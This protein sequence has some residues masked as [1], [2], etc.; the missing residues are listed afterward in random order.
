[1]DVASG[2]AKRK[3]NLGDTLLEGVATVMDFL[4]DVAQQIVLLAHKIIVAAHDHYHQTKQA[5]LSDSASVLDF[6]G[7]SFFV[8]DVAREIA[9][10]HAVFIEHRLSDDVQE[11][12]IPFARVGASR[13]IYFLLSHKEEA[14]TRQNLLRGVIEG[15]SGK[16]IEGFHNNRLKGKGNDANTILTAEGA[17]CRFGLQT[18]DGRLFH[19]EG[20]DPTL[21]KAQ[22]KTKITKQGL[23][24][25]GYARL[26]TGFGQVN[27]TSLSPINS[28]Q[29][30]E[31]STAYSLAEQLVTHEDITAYLQ[32]V[33]SA[34]SSSDSKTT[35]LIISFHDFLRRY[36]PQRFAGI[37]RAVF[38]GD[39]K[40]ICL[41]GGNF[42][43]VDFS[44]AT[45]YGDISQT[46][47]VD[48]RLHGTKFV[49]ITATRSANFTRANLTYAS[50]QAVHF[51]QVTF[52]QTQWCYANLQ[53]SRFSS[54]EC[55][56]T[57]WAY[58]YYLETVRCESESV[59]LIDIQQSQEK[60][61]FELLKRLDELDKEMLG[62]YEK[63]DLINEQLANLKLEVDSLKAFSES[64]ATSEKLDRLRRE[65]KTQREKLLAL[66]AKQDE[67]DH[68]IKN[69]N[70]EMQAQLI[71]LK[72]S[73]LIHL[74]GIQKIS[75]EQQ[76][77]I[78]QQ[79][80]C[81]FQLRDQL[82]ALS[83]RV[84]R[85]E[86]KQ[87]AQE[88]LLDDHETRL[89]D[90]ERQVSKD[91]FTG[92]LRQII[93][94]LAQVKNKVE[95]EKVFDKLKQLLSG[96]ATKTVDNFLKPEECPWS[97]LSDINQYHRVAHANDSVN[98]ELLTVQK[99]YKKLVNIE[100]NRLLLRFNPNESHIQAEVLDELYELGFSGFLKLDQRKRVIKAL[101][102]QL[103]TPD[104]SS[105][106]IGGEEYPFALQHARVLRLYIDILVQQ[107]LAAKAKGVETEVAGTK[108]KR[109][110]LTSL[111][112]TLYLKTG[113]RSLKERFKA[114]ED[115]VFEQ[116]KVETA[117]KNLTTLSR[118]FYPNRR[119]R[120][121]FYKD[122]SDAIEHELI[123]A[124][125]GL[126]CLA[127][128]F[129][130]LPSTVRSAELEANSIK[131][132]P[133]VL[134]SGFKAFQQLSD[135]NYL[136]LLCWRSIGSTLIQTIDENQ[137]KARLLELQKTLAEAIKT[138]NQTLSYGLL[139]VLRCIT[140]YAR[141]I[142]LRSLAFLGSSESPLGIVHFIEA[143][144]KEGEMASLHYLGLH[145]CK[146]LM[147]NPSHPAFL[148]LV[149]RLFFF[150]QPSV[151]KIEVDKIVELFKGLLGAY[152]AYTHNPNYHKE[153]RTLLSL[154]LTKRLNKLALISY[155]GVTLPELEK[156]ILDLAQQALQIN[157]PDLWSRWAEEHTQE[158]AQLHRVIHQF[159]YVGSQQATTPL[160][161]ARYY[162]SY[163]TLSLLTDQEARFAV[164]CCE[165]NLSL[166]TA[167]NRLLDA[168]FVHRD[169]LTQRN[170]EEVLLFETHLKPFCEA[171]LAVKQDYPKEGV[172]DYL[173]RYLLRAFFP[174]E[175]LHNSLESLLRSEQFLLHIPTEIKNWLIQQNS[176]W[177][178]EG[179]EIPQLNHSFHVEVVSH[180]AQG[181][182]SLGCLNAQALALLDEQGQLKRH[183]KYAASKTPVNCL[184]G[185]SSLPGL[186]LKA[187]PGLPAYE[188]A[189]KSL[190]WH[191]TG[192]WHASRLLW[193]RM[194]RG[195]SEVRFYPVLV[196]ATLPGSTLNSFSQSNELVTQQKKQDAQFDPKI[197]Q[198]TFSWQVIFALVS[199]LGDAKS[200]NYILSPEGSVQSIDQEEILGRAFFPPQ[201]LPSEQGRKI[202]HRIG[203]KNILFCMPEMDE[204]VEND[205][206][207]QFLALPAETLFRVFLADMA[208]YNRQLQGLENLEERY[209][210]RMGAG[211]K[212]EA[213]MLKMRMRPEALQQSYYALIELQKF[214]R[215]E[216]QG[217]RRVSHRDLL[218]YLE[219]AL[220]A[221][222]QRAFD[223]YATPA[224]RFKVITTGLY[225]IVETETIEETPVATSEK[226]SA[227]PRVV[228]T[229]HHKSLSTVLLL[230]H[231][232]GDCRKKEDFEQ[233]Q[234][235]YGVASESPI[236][237]D[238]CTE[239][240]TTWA[241]H[242]AVRQAL[243]AMRR[244]DFSYLQT[245]LQEDTQARPSDADLPLRLKWQ[246]RQRSLFNF[247]FQRLDFSQINIDEKLF[248]EGLINLLGKSFF[249]IKKLHIIGAKTLSDEQFEKIIS[250][251][252]D[253]GVIKLENCALLGQD[254]FIM[255]GKNCPRLAVIIIDNLPNLE[256]ITAWGYE[257]R[258]TYPSLTQLTVAHCPQLKLINI[259]A[260]NLRHLCLES[261]KNLNELRT[262]SKN[263]HSL[264]LIR[265]EKITDSEFGEIAAD[266]T[267]LQK[268][269][270]TGCTQLQDI[271][272]VMPKLAVLKA[273]GCDA[274]RVFAARSDVLTH[275]D[276]SHNPLLT[277]EGLTD[278]MT[279]LSWLRSPS[280]DCNGSGQLQGMT[281]VK[282]GEACLIQ[283]GM[284]ANEAPLLF[285]NLQDLVNRKLVKMDLRRHQIGDAG[286]RALAEVLKEDRTLIRMD[287][288]GNKI[289]NAG[290]GALAEVL[291][292]NSTLTQIDLG[293]NQ[294]SDAGAGAL[295]EALKEN[296]TLTQMDL[297][298]NKI[299]DAGARAL[300]DA[301]KGDNTMEDVMTLNIT[302]HMGLR[303]LA[304]NPT[305]NGTL[306]QMDL[307]GNIIDSDVLDDIKFLLE[308]NHALVRYTHSS[309][310]AATSG[311]FFQPSLPS[312]SGKEIALLRKAP[313]EPKLAA[314]N[315]P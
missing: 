80:F 47:F 149:E 15:R 18:V 16:G 279:V 61:L 65:M 277:E 79:Q 17:Y 19:G 4:P 134:K 201:T 315:H 181:F 301:L 143:H 245:L 166:G 224:E 236:S 300:I 307:Q 124:C 48:A 275:L 306:T 27:T 263:L 67:F 167:S 88:I 240:E 312:E 103:A 8:E 250:H 211:E 267:R 59:S 271:R 58:A 107:K 55:L 21:F 203:I 242:Q 72:E 109:G 43:G 100:L 230:H 104:V 171:L 197:F 156:Q 82:R 155:E 264:K 232:L 168:L 83:S 64:D 145:T 193:F 228:V 151:E 129:N 174:S 6:F 29:V 123:Q 273:S 239:L 164:G 266:W 113:W 76:K 153:A 66:L 259:V 233:K 45:L 265:A 139:D 108:E 118:K 206:L 138:G 199:Y 3:T 190:Q 128:D 258:Y 229:Q 299:G 157:I 212:T 84:N 137:T 68:K 147:K 202:R 225:D 226:A 185:S 227:A 81:L 85:L 110:P 136:D 23:A 71:N 94:E 214:I 102:E 37:K 281:T 215:D 22:I 5:Q 220:G 133:G 289:G 31:V 282:R 248:I 278:V 314:A 243:Q 256:K 52:H 298:G 141:S 200:D 205:V 119:S 191:L 9:R 20:K 208:D 262:Q 217:S 291:K 169:R 165:V 302:G 186:H 234:L 180:D 33:N 161:K 237:V 268:L 69:L 154:Y 207:T 146:E 115:C 40:E 261:S 257:Y 160:L 195:E 91:S 10:S 36:D 106:F 75:G 213:S 216:R 308:Q 163:L 39:L 235:P 95:A 288:K 25:Y 73:V 296:R 221:L 210:K 114:P 97:L 32:S 284:S 54:C 87:E 144:W 196:T 209:I 13:I 218:N 183:A 178:T 12:I 254:S 304:Q 105:D 42:S 184:P 251:F 269:E 303:M 130:A 60:M 311:R 111:M 24:K 173:Y 313:V 2:R 170:G 252:P 121:N 120:D 96:A 192:S 188:I 159:F 292:I 241:V 287:L 238:A 51:E 49:D 126:K 99:Y 244:G 297:K 283:A 53:N 14:I 179:D 57:Q 135:L 253:L 46:Q 44:G 117:C 204:P 198:K 260:E 294:I 255:L 11:G 7:L 172:V 56:G 35:P 1:M 219:P 309:S 62:H 249:F 92:R 162:T 122:L 89:E 290:A 26:S 93:I 30:L 272:I 140:L 182:V 28:A 177:V 41:K 101:L 176:L 293:F 63:I 158:A 276:V 280:L 150:E 98:K 127:G 77:R 34:C 223:E 152:Q 131:A 142:E 231:L 86:I 132:I 70:E 222:Y 116:A 78:E 286:A 270:I 38:S 90:I 112:E 274:L 74:L 175:T 189:A 148:T 247:V 295:A 305:V 310:S 125:E 285:V 187:H 246:A 50:A 194:M